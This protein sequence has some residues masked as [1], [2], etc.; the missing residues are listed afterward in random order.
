MYQLLNFINLWY[1][2]IGVERLISPHFPVWTFSRLGNVGTMEVV[3]CSNIFH[4]K[5]IY[6][7]SQSRGILGGPEQAA[8][9]AD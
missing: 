7:P 8:L 5:V 4:L 3:V 1:W 9:S 6:R 2:H